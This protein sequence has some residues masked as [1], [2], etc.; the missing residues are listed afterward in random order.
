MPGV[1]VAHASMRSP[2]GI[3][4][5]VLLSKPVGASVGS[6]QRGQQAMSSSSIGQF[7]CTESSFVATLACPVGGLVLWLLTMRLETV[8][9]RNSSTT[10]PMIKVFRQFILVSSL[11]VRQ[12]EV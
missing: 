4:S 7:S 11:G 12:N 9:A 5:F 10:T 3:K 2:C 8:A 6:K 1:G